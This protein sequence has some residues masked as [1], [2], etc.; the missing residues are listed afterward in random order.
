MKKQ[1]TASTEFLKA[2]A[3]MGNT[4]TKGSRKLT[5]RKL[6]EM[7]SVKNEVFNVEVS[8]CGSFKILSKTSK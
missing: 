3:Y 7:L 5:W 4:V 8:E 1:L 6:D 2:R